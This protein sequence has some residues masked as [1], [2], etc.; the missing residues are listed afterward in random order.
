MKRFQELTKLFDDLYLAFEGCQC[1]EDVSAESKKKATNLE[2]FDVT[3][4]VSISCDSKKAMAG[5][6]TP[7]DTC[8]SYQQA[9]AS[10][11]SNNL[12]TVLTLYS[13]R[14]S[15]TLPQTINQTDLTSGG[16]MLTSV[17]PVIRMRILPQMK[18]RASTL[19]RICPKEPTTA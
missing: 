5:T 1:S 18:I 13:V 3:A 6:Q 2:V 14:G 12:P 4:N 17:V 11:M 19:R 10:S 8:D 15:S 7:S 16:L 9:I